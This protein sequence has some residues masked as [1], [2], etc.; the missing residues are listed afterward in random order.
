[1]A[2]YNAKVGETVYTVQK[3][4]FSISF[5]KYEIVKVYKDSPYLERNN[6]AIGRDESG[7]NIQLWLVDCFSE[8]A[9]EKKKQALGM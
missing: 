9:I 2:K 5:N 6:R 4:Q 1:M 7:L 3:S 8:S